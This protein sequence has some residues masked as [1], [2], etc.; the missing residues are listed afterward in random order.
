MQGLSPASGAYGRHLSRRD[1]SEIL[2][3]NEIGTRTISPK[4]PAVHHKGADNSLPVDSL[5]SIWRGLHNIL[6]RLWVCQEKDVFLNELL[7]EKL[8]SV[9]R[10]RTPKLPLI[11]KTLP[12]FSC[13]LNSGSPHGARVSSGE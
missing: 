5:V 4:Q 2:D 7:S 10:E 8:P 12:Y 11:R 13:H 6:K 9:R 1:R 3:T